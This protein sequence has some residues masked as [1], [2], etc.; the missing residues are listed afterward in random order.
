VKN[1]RT[2]SQYKWVDTHCHLQLMKSSNSESDLFNLHYVI[3]PGVDVS[4]SLKAE[5]MSNSLSM[6]SYWSAGLH[7]HEAD[8]LSDCRE[9][10]YNLM[11]RA[12]LIG[13][14]GLDF[15]R[16][17][18]TRDNQI[19]NLLFHLEVAEE[20]SKPIIIHCRDSFKE[21]YQVLQEGRYS[22][23]VIL[24]SWT[25]GNKW[26]KQF[27]ELGVY[28]SISGIV[29]YETAHDLQASVKQIPLDRLLLETDVPY[30]TPEPYK[31]QA[32][33]PSNIMFTAQ[34]LSELVEIELEELSKITIQN[35]DVLLGRNH[36]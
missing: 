32:N 23:P 4:T 22:M 20:M 15:Y 7:P 26:T 27:K 1:N 35:T 25:G 19:E 34:K 36:E 12:D 29:T 28:F 11:E 5:D 10:L 8:N 16:N 24:H 9:E 21:V 17:M 33:V 3:I 14:T 31:G 13:E 2:L 6:D 18:S 30:L